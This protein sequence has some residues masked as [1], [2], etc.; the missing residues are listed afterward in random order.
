MAEG[1][2]LLDP[3]GDF[4]GW[5]AAQ[6]GQAS[7][8]QAMARELGISDY[9]A[10]LACSE[11]AQVQQE[12]LTFARQRLP[13]AFYAVLR[14][15]VRGLS[16]GSPSTLS[17]REGGEARRPLSLA[18]LDAIMATLRGL[19]DELLLSAQRFS[20]LTP[21][22]MPPAPSCPPIET[23]YLSDMDADSR[24]EGEL[25]E[26]NLQTTANE[27]SH[28]DGDADTEGG[29]NAALLDQERLPE[30]DAVDSGHSDDRVEAEQETQSWTGVQ[31]KT[32]NHWEDFNDIPE[33]SLMG[34][35]GWELK[36]DPQESNGG[37][38]EHQGEEEMGKEEPNEEGV[39]SGEMLVGVSDGTEDC[40]YREWSEWGAQEANEEF[41]GE[42]D[43]LSENQ[44][45]VNLEASTSAL[46]TTTPD[47]IRAPSPLR[48]PPPHAFPVPLPL[49][50]K[51]NRRQPGNKHQARTRGTKAARVRGGGH[52][53]RGVEGR[54][55]VARG[56]SIEGNEGREPRIYAG[57]FACELCGRRF[58]QSSNL[59]RHRRTHTGERP[60]RCDR[61]GKRFSQSS[62][63][64]RHIRT[65]VRWQGLVQL[66]RPPLIG[67]S[68]RLPVSA[69]RF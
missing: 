59:I 29:H 19:S 6:G 67:V 50:S 26:E 14:R 7:F 11:D 48:L 21:S 46:S 16:P 35:G 1:C 9:D 45:E 63:L 27:E 38:R 51:R 5:M 25:G 33:P 58:T 64:T 54:E 56:V 52:G 47:A 13:F 32:E 42:S 49:P 3:R 20:D 62:N 4:A 37:E 30:M 17:V 66:A 41:W 24:L 53:Q 22:F 57:S 15:L 36:L 2:M 60:Y 34:L 39:D 55:S 18:L 10:L 31:V 28:W 68:D 69:L 44:E 12:L 8:A 61:C 23:P 43:V 40:S 65:H